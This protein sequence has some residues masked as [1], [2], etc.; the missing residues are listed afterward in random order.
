M[1]ALEQIKT[2]LNVETFF[3]LNTRSV[4]GFYLC[5]VYEVE[6]SLSKI[7]LCYSASGNDREAHLLSWKTIKPN[8][9]Q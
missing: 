8:T 2:T 5:L 4:L 7:L 3:F 1:K 9:R 6:L